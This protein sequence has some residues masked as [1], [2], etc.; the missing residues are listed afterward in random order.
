MN[1]VYKRSL[2]IILALVVAILLIPVSSSFAG[3]GDKASDFS[4]TDLNGKEVKLSEFAGK[5][6]LLNFWAT[7]CPPCRAEIPHFI[8][9][10]DEYAEKGLVILGVSHDQK[11]STVRSWLQEN[12]VNYPVMMAQSEVSNKYQL[13]LPQRDRGGIPFTFIIDKKGKI[14]HQDVGYRDKAA[15]E[16]KIIPLLSEE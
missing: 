5:V 7:W 10:A 13:Y 15:W 8:E 3:V 12:P 16:S 11:E 2:S 4:L 14:R 6:V 1:T 9:L